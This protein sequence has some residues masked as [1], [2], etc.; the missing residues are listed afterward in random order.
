MRKFS[1]LAVFSLVVG[2]SLV[3]TGCSQVRTLQ[4]RLAF[5]EANGLYQGQEWKE[6]AQ[7]YE[8]VIAANPTDPQLLTAYFFLGNSY[9]NMYRPGRSNDPANDA[10]LTKAI[11]N[12]K[13]AAERV[14]DNPQIRTLAL[15]YL[16]AAYGSDK[17]NDP[18]Q[19]EPLLKQMIDEDPNEAANYFLLSRIYE[20]AGDY[21]NAEAT[22]TKAREVRATDPVVYTTLAAYYDRQGDFDKLVEALEA[23]VAQ[24]PNNPEAH[25]TIATYYFNKASRDFS[26]TDAE[27]GKYAQAG[28]A[29][30]DKALG[31]N[32]DYMEALV[33]KNLLLRVQATVE[34]NVSRQQALLK[35]ADQLRN[36]AEEIRK[37]KAAGLGK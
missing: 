28:I 2:L 3:L 24:E 19:A 20:D 36:R 29:A 11:E 6:A 16:V 7:K 26:L 13:L 31:L 10:L 23:R 5:R 21:E 25:Y 32:K 33:F 4:A 14:R 37:L 35:E 22:L 1:S 18:S 30:T 9:D 15:Q 8:E 17:L 27:K 34:R 12:Y